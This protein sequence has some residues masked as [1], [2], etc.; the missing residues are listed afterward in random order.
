MP[1]AAGDLRARQR[2]LLAERLGERRPDL[3]VEVVDV[4]VDVK[5]Q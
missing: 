4:V 2:Q 3:R 5:L 1:F